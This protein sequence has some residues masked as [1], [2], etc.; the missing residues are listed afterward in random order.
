MMILIGA[1]RVSLF[2]GV[3]TERD[4]EKFKQPAVIKYKTHRSSED[5]RK[6]FSMRLT[7]EIVC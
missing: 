7:V 1:A 3:A 2:S 5:R 4:I 6:V